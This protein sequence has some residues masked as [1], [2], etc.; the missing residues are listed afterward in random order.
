MYAVLLIKSDEYGIGALPC[1]LYGC[2]G[3]GDRAVFDTFADADEC[4]EKFRK[5]NPTALYA[6]ANAHDVCF[7]I[8]TETIVTG[9]IVA[10]EFN[11]DIDEEEPD[12][13]YEK[14]GIYEDEDPRCDD[15]RCAYCW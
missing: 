10:Q 12:G 11:G 5:D 4:M 13:Y 7:R 3:Y 8:E 15:P 9:V 2:S 6:I 14:E 1:V